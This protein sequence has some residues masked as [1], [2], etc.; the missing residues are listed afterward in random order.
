MATTDGGKVAVVKV[1]R[2]TEGEWKE[3]R[4]RGRG[5]GGED[6]DIQ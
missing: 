4:R 1:Q 6:K 2:K 3:A 5:T